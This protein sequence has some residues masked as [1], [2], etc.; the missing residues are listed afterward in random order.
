MDFMG[1]RGKSQ[2]KGILAEKLEET[3]LQLHT[4]RVRLQDVG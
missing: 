4:L 1:N 3:T 2:E